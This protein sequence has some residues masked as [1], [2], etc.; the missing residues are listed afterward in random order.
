MLQH[1]RNLVNEIIKRDREGV[2]S[3][4]GRQPN[5]VGVREAEGGLGL[6]KRGVVN[7]AKLLR[8]RLTQM[9]SQESPLDLQRRGRW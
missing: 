3:E 7:C 8:G 5:E 9:L 6:R 1:L 4:G 2:A